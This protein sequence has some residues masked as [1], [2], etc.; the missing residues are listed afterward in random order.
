MMGFDANILVRYLVQDDPAHT[1]KV[2]TLVGHL[3]E[4]GEPAFLNLVVLC[5]TVWVLDRG[6]G[7]PRATIADVLEKLL[8]TQQFEFEDRDTCWKALGRFKSGTA[9]F[10]DYIIGEKNVS[11]GCEGTVTF[12]RGLVGEPRFEML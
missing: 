1:A 2:M 5:E 11:L 10:A 8:L 7:Y 12:D 9:D 6:Y 4:T 3:V